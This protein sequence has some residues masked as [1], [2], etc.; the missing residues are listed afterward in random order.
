M[1]WVKLKIIMVPV[2]FLFQ[3]SF[4]RLLFLFLVLNFILF[5]YGV[6]YY[7]SRRIINRHLTLFFVFYIFCL[8]YYFLVFLF[9][10]V[11][12]FFFYGEWCPILL[13]ILHN[14]ILQL[15]YHLSSRNLLKLLVSLIVQICIFFLIFPSN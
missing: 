1:I 7:L 11:F 14:F 9:F 3:R 4:F 13:L 6:P 5:S 10:L 15:F 8:L 12:S 2:S